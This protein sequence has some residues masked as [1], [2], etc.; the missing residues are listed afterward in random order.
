MHSLK[1]CALTDS[2]IGFCLDVH[3]GNGETVFLP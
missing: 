1:L 3:A 2:V